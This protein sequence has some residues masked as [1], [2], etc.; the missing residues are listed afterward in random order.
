MARALLPFWLVTVM[1]ALAACSPSQQERANTAAD[2]AAVGAR[3]AM[4]GLTY[5]EVEGSMDC[6]RD[7]SGQAAGFAY[8][9]EHDIENDA[10][11]NNPND[12]FVEG[13]KAYGEEI[14]QCVNAAHEAVMQGK[15]PADHCPLLRSVLG[16]RATV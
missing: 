8:A 15:Q 1:C 3:N 4:R 13:C 9:Q 6:A 10:D 7:C 16:P 11:C 12:S 14:D 2:R 5:E